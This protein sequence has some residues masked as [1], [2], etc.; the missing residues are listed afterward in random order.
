MAAAIGEILGN[1]YSLIA[2]S[3]VIAVLFV[4]LGAKGLGDRVSVVA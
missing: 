1:A 4:V 3:A 2:G